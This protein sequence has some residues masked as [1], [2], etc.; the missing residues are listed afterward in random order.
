MFDLQP[1]ARPSPPARLD[2]PASPIRVAEVLMNLIECGLAVCSRDGELLFANRAAHLE[3]DGGGVL[4]CQNGSIRGPAGSQS[5][6]AHAIQDAVVRSRCRLLWIGEGSAR[7]MLVVRPLSL[8]GLR[9]PT[10]LVMLGRRSPC[11]ALGLEML[12]IR[13]QLTYAERRVMKAL[14]ASRSAREIADAHCVSVPTIRTQIQAIREKVGVRSIDELLLHAALVP[15][16]GTL[17]EER[18][19]A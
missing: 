6:L 15:P 10:A 11:S 18:A 13:H 7:L 3:L 9:E 8:E 5:D 16:I 14:V 19:D 2:S 4:H 17:H 1:L 12:A